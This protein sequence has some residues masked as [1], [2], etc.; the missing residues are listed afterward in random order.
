MAQPESRGREV[1][2]PREAAHRA[3][4][5]AGGFAVVA[6]R[7]QSTA[8]VWASTRIAN[9]ESTLG[10]ASLTWATVALGLAAAS[11]GAGGEAISTSATRASEASRR[12][13]VRIRVPS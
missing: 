5:L 13:V 1:H 9:P 7:A 11:A 2:R 12:L 6:C 3:R 4:A 10:P 8:P